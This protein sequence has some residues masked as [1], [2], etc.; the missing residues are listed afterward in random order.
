MNSE[1]A[2]SLIETATAEAAKSSFAVCVTILDAAS[3][4]VAFHRMDAANIGP[5][6]VSQKKA[7]TAALFQ[8]DSLQLGQAAQ[9]G[10]AIY[11]IEN[12]NGGLISFGGGVVLRDKAGVVV[13]AIGV[14][15][16]TVEAD[17][18]IAQAAAAS[19]LI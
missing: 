8:I 15:G 19:L 2:K 4:L 18:V 7:R 13:G 3:H 14:A 12:T 10:G 1:L 6:E 17:E 11:T 9:P 16:A 5:I